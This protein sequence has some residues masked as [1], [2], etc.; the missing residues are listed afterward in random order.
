MQASLSAGSAPPRLSCPLPSAGLWILLLSELLLV[1]DLCPSEPLPLV[2]LPS[3][4]CLP[5]VSLSLLLCLWILQQIRFP[6]L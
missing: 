1:S 4:S 6:E 5:W 3:P 2:S